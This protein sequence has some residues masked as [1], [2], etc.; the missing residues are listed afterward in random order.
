MP[1]VA[2]SLPVMRRWVVVLRTLFLCAWWRDAERAIAHAG[3]K[4]RRI[5]L[6]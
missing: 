6:S 2:L 1:H 3:A 5:E 4:R